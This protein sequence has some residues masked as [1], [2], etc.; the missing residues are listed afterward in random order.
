MAQRCSFCGKTENQHGGKA[1]IDPQL[2]QLA[3]G[4]RVRFLQVWGA[5]SSYQIFGPGDVVLVTDYW[6][7][8]LVKAGI[9]ES[10]PIIGVAPETDPASAEQSP[11][12]QPTQKG[13]ADSEGGRE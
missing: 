9:A 6:H 4:R 12:G 11:A 10:L 13:S 7:G 1:C 2:R 5:P 8:V 3:K